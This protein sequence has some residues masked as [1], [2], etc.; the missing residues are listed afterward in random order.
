M[1]LLVS[2]ADILVV[3]D[4]VGDTTSTLSDADLHPN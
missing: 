3:G 1:C 2:L 4:R